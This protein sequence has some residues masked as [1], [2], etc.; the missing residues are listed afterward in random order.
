MSILKLLSKRSDLLTNEERQIVIN[1]LQSLTDQ[2]ISDII[3]RFVSHD[4]VLVVNWF[5][6]DHLKTKVKDMI[7][8]DFE[9]SEDYE[10]IIDDLDL[11]DL[12]REMASDFALNGF[13]VE[14]LE[15]I[16]C[17]EYDDEGDDDDDDE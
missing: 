14:Y 1:E 9:I 15:P 13:L 6:R 8:S 3:G 11:E 4:R 10:S 12:G 7:E 17:K 16:V 2:E 5:T